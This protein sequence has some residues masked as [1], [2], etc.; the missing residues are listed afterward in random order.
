MAIATGL[1]VLDYGDQTLLLDFDSTAEV[2]AWIEAL[3]DADL[4]D[5][6]HLLPVRGVVTAH[7]GTPWRPLALLT[8]RNGLTFLEV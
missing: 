3:P 1:G 4:L 7:T 2:L 8:L 6:V 5:V